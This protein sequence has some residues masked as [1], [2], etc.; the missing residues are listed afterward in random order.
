MQP[1]EANAVLKNVQNKFLDV[2]EEIKDLPP[3]YKYKVQE[4]LS[5]AET[6]VSMYCDI[7]NGI[8]PDIFQ[9]KE[10]LPKV[11]TKLNISGISEL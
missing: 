8:I 4:M 2:M 7:Q 5:C 10:E 3:G 6:V 9:K 1:Q 11:S